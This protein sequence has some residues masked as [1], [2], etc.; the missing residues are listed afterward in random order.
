MTGDIRVNV[1]ELRT[2]ALS[3]REAAGGLPDAPAPFTSSGGDDLSVALTNGTNEKEAPLVEAMPRIR[4]DA[5]GTAANIGVAADRYE[6][7]D[8]EAHD[9]VQAR[10]ADFDSTFGAPGTA[11]GGGAMDAMSQFG[12]LMQMP[13]QMAQQLGQVPM[14]MAQ[15]LGQIPQAVMQGVEQIGQMAG[16]AES[17]N[18]S[19]QPEPGQED[20]RDEREDD[21]REKDE[22]QSARAEGAA[23]EQSGAERAPVAAPPTGGIPDGSPTG[24]VPN[25]APPDRT[26]SDPSIVL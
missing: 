6:Q 2:G 19:Q 3:F 21:E 25:A 9:K 15:Q 12:Q 24:P 18:E 11:G 8:Q 13:M 20:A 4:A 23:A 16:G 26:T 5:Q 7:T 17:N 22:Q 1:P 14:Q 10:I